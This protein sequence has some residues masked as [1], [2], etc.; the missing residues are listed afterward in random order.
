MWEHLSDTSGGKRY[1]QRG[2]AETSLKT[3]QG[4]YSYYSSLE[5]EASVSQI[6]ALLSV[7]LCSYKLNWSILEKLDKAA[8]TQCNFTAPREKFSFKFASNEDE[9]GQ[10]GW[11]GS[12]R[13]P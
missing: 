10:A 1:S 2:H 5:R 3:T 9:M 7:T 6:S 11:L 13:L 8:G 4:R 12:C